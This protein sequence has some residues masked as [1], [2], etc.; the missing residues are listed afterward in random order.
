M[1]NSSNTPGQFAQIY[2]PYFHCGETLFQ[3]I[4][5]RLVPALQDVRRIEP[6]CLDQ[7][8]RERLTLP[9]HHLYNWQSH[10]CGYPIVSRIVP[11]HR[12]QAIRH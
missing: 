3:Q 9:V 10:E 11:A 8:V 5:N 1:S 12:F 4:E 7:G 6:M 2:A